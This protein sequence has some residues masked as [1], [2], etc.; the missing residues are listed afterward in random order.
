MYKRL[1][2]NVKREGAWATTK[3]IKKKLREETFERIIRWLRLHLACDTPNNLHESIRIGHPTGIV[4]SEKAELGEDIM[5]Q[6][7]VTIGNKSSAAKDCYP[8]IEDGVTIYSGAAIIG[9]VTV[10]ENCE[11]GANSVVIDDIPANSVAVGAPAHV[12]G[13]AQ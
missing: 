5:I 6:Q 8:V 3:S 12:V 9:D 11:I 2:R 4:V 7:N 1:I 10:G 13:K